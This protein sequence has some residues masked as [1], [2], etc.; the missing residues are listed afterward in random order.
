MDQK[1]VLEKLLKIAENQQKII[2]KLAQMPP[3]ATPTSEVSTF[4]PG[5]GAPA[6]TA[7]APTGARPAAPPHQDLQAMMFA[8]NPN[9]AHAVSSVAF[10]GPGAISVSF[11]EGQAT[12]PNYDAVLA[13]VK[14]LESE[15]KLQG[16][17]KVHVA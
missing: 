17:H 2:M 5:Q 6:P 1:K 13:T 9:L 3:A 14:K 10:A 15:R 4:T 12:Q 7:P 8:A 16:G 11:K